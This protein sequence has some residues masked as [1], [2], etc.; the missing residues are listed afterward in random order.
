MEAFA[1]YLLKSIIWL[2]G[3]A[4][5]YLL[6]LR[7]ER[8]FQIKRLYLLTGII[9]SL[10]FPVIS[11]HYRV[12][13]P[14]PAVS[15]FNTPVIDLPPGTV[16]PAVTQVESFDYRII[17]LILYVSGILFLGYRIIRHMVILRKTINKANINSIG[18]ARLVRIS[19]FPASFSFFNYVFINPS[20]G[21]A[22]VREIMN[23][24]LVHVHQK[25]WLDLLLIEML[26]LFQWINPFVWI[27]TGFIRLNNE[28]LADELALQRS[29]NPGNYRAAL[30]N[31]LFRSPVI[32]LSNSFNYS[33]NKKRFDMMKKIV[34]SPYRK[35]KIFLVLPVFA[36]I[37]YAFATPEYNYVASNDDTNQFPTSLSAPDL[38][39]RGE[40]RKEDGTP[41]P[42]VAIIV[43]GTSTG[44]I[45]DSNGIFVIGNVPKN[46]ILTFSCRGYLT[47]TVKAGKQDVVVRMVKDPE[48][49]EEPEVTGYRT[50]AQIIP[51]TVNIPN[52]ADGTQANPLIIIDGVATDRKNLDGLD[53]G[54]IA[55]ISVRKDA[56]ETA[57]YGERGKNGVILITT[58]N[59]LQ[60][61]VKG[62]VVDENGRPLQGVNV[63]SPGIAGYASVTT[64]D[65]DGRFSF[66]NVQDDAVLLFNLV[67]YKSIFIK[68]DYTKE[69]S[70]K[71]EKDPDYK[72][73]AGPP[74]T[75]FLQMP[76]RVVTI[77]GVLTDKTI[78]E[79]R[80][81]LG[82]NYGIM[83][84]ARGQASGD[85]PAVDTIK[86]I[87]R[88]KALEMGL[89][90]PFP[91]LT[92][93]DYP[94][95][96]GQQVSGFNKWVA[97]Q[98]K[99]PP[100]ARAKNVEGWVS[101]N[102]TVGLDGTISNITSTI[103]VDPLLSDEV[104]RVVKLSKWF[105]PKNPDVDEPFITEVTLKF[106]LPD[107]ISSTTPFVV[108]EQMPH[109]PGGEVALL[110][111]IKNNTRYPEEAKARKIEGRV[112][113][114]F[115]V[116]DEG[117]TEAISVLKGVH[118]LLDAE[119]I[120]IVSTFPK[121]EP[122]MQGG[123]PVDVWYACPITFSLTQTDTPQ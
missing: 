96:E 80:K 29:S 115:C 3:F 93:D 24:E 118:P 56:S 53:P 84:M 55:S 73:P 49:K 36:I 86:I 21:E 83:N 19:S 37:L 57:P 20:V 92:P 46:A 101:V 61:P 16:I 48:Y 77:D 70:V 38:T 41:L 122:G 100:E 40:V 68:A 111:F 42:N 79:A 39:I 98:V 91:R 99:Y 119:A 117:R 60:K 116:T 28:Y 23:H 52:A 59:P 1:I 76:P 123:Q 30:M 43:S 69:M 54:N 104:I 94:T 81:D 17:L 5:I 9:V 120:R 12:E 71:M 97:G 62:I 114:R 15:E 7:Y 27:Y 8:F 32:S 34:T 106:K 109:Y 33:L 110:D 26:R 87:T 2:T 66:S 31:Q 95:F 75:Q 63:T 78:E 45:T 89:K 107:Q 88:E 102:L 105:P 50:N 64:T 85:K 4:L 18:P 51:G 13:V 22:E 58:K 6:F 47:Q 121:F 103:P 72:A 25:H 74:Q 82:Y 14:A 90:P 65:S 108:V 11:I 44:T 113:L 10:I 67:G 112:I 35:L